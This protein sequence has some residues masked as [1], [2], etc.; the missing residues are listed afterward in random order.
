[1]D[2]YQSIDD[3]LVVFLRGSG[4]QELKRK[5][6]ELTGDRVEKAT[7]V[8]LGQIARQEPVRL[9]TLAC[10]LAVELSTVSRKAAELE[11]EG[12]VER[13]GDETDKRA[14]VLALTEAGR[15]LL[16]RARA[17]RRELLQELTAGWTAEERQ[18]F[19]RLLGQLADGFTHYGRTTAE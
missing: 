13:S 8:L 16:E 19:A 10:E 11:R 5:L 9:S 4:N 7:L 18:I 17:A 2:V 3:A 15:S 12:L 14:H 1:M 6:A